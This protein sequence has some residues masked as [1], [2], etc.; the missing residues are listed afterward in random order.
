MSR[1]HCICFISAKGGAGKTVLSA[2]LGLL[3]AAMGRP[4]TIADC[5]AAT[6]GLTLLYLSKLNR[7]KASAEQVCGGIFDEDS[8]SGASSIPGEIAIAP[9]LS[10]VPATYTMESTER[11][12]VEHFSARLD[13]LILSLDRTPDHDAGYLILDA[14]AGTDSFAYAAVARADDVVIVSEYD[15]VSAEGIER[16]RIEFGSHLPLGRTWTLFN[17]LL[18]DFATEVG[19]FLK[20]A[21]FLPPM[22]WNADVIRAYTRRELAIDAENGNTYTLGMLAIIGSLLPDELGATVEEW[23]QQRAGVLREPIIT[24]LS[25]LEEEI[26]QL[27]RSSVEI[28]YQLA[29]DERKIP[30]RRVSIALGGAFVVIVGLSLGLWS[31]TLPFSAIWAS[32]GVAAA[33]VTAT[34]AVITAWFARGGSRESSVQLAA[35]KRSIERQIAD[36][37]EQRSRYQALMLADTDELLSGRGL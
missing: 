10:L 9:R 3:I 26:A 29:Q 33:A 7:A 1:P 18:P 23:K 24:K 27:E 5:D 37:T 28:S 8:E 12:S 15:P 31:T 22:P 34:A 32:V 20:V 14:Q 35:T 17:K 21:G 6:N 16:L 36:L 30:R 13:K 2:S 25:N 19:S 4:V 11:V